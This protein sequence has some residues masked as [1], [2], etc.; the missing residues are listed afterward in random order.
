MPIESCTYRM[1]NSSS[2]LSMKYRQVSKRMSTPSSSTR[3]MIEQTKFINDFEEIKSHA[4]HNEE[5]KMMSLHLKS[6]KMRECAMPL[7]SVDRL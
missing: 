1:V 3:I 4:L 2:R 6:R 5:L 7:S